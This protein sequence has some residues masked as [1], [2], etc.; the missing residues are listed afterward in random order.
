M[1]TENS[2]NRFVDAQKTDYQQALSE[3]KNGRKRSHWM[4]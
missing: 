4:W 1:A 3:I 2:L